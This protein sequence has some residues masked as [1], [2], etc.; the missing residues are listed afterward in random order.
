MFPLARFSGFS[1]LFSSNDWYF[2]FT[3]ICPITSHFNGGGNP[4][5]PEDGNLRLSLSYMSGINRLHFRWSPFLIPSNSRNLDGQTSPLVSPFLSLKIA[6]SMHESLEIGKP[7]NK[8]KTCR[9]GGN[10]NQETIEKRPKN[11]SSTSV[12][13]Q[14]LPANMIRKSWYS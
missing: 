9:Y 8:P 4:K 11:S 2:S 10:G 3:A 14:Y 5:P 7:Q 13:D 12:G 6:W 1:Q